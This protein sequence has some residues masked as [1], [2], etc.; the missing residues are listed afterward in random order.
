MSDT[1]RRFVNEFATDNPNIPNRF[2]LE[3]AADVVQTLNP[4]NKNYAPQLSTSWG[5]PLQAIANNFVAG[6]TKNIFQEAALN[7]GAEGAIS[8][9][10]GLSIAKQIGTNINTPG[11]LGNFEATKL[12]NLADKYGGGTV[13]PTPSTILRGIL[14][15]GSGRA[16]GGTSRSAINQSAGSTAA[17]TVP[18]EFIVPE[19]PQ[20]QLLLIM[21]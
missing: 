2:G 18:E 20:A 17:N 21:L 13:K 9:A 7:T 10:E 11:T 15:G 1:T 6:G 5:K 16:A 12:K 8:P 14:P 3:T 19:L 4:M